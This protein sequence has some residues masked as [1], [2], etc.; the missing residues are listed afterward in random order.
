MANLPAT[1]ANTNTELER[2][3]IILALSSRSVQL[4]FSLWLLYTEPFTNLIVSKG[5]VLVTR[6]LEESRYSRGRFGARAQ[7]L[8][9]K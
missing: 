8:T 4:S 2:A 5:L 1:L 3:A 6:F 7:G 9:S